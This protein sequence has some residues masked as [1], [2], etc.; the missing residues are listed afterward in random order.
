MEQDLRESR[1]HA[2]FPGATQGSPPTVTKALNV[3]KDELVRPHAFDLGHKGDSRVT[4]RQL[5]SRAV[6]EISPAP[7]P[8]GGHDLNGLGGAS[9]TGGG[10]LVGGGNSVMTGMPGSPDAL[11]G[12]GSM[13][14]SPPQ[15]EEG[16]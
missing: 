4:L 10:S 7:P 16:A 13:S 5:C 2:Y 12:F 1:D 15:N 11:A 8:T 14:L 6:L 9:L 3:Y